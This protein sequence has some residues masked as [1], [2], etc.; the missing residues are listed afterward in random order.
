MSTPFCDPK[1]AFFAARLLFFSTGVSEWGSV[2]N[3]W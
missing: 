3:E 2:Q 1:A